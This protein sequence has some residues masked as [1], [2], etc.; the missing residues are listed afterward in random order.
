M[1]RLDEQPTPPAELLAFWRAAG[2]DAQVYAERAASR[3]MNYCDS[4]TALPLGYVR[5]KEGDEVSA[6]GRRWR[7]HMGGGHA[8]E[9]VTL[10]SVDDDLA[11]VGDQILADIT[12]N[13]GVYATEPEA[14][15]VGDWFD[16]CARLA[17]VAEDRHLILPGHKQPFVGAPGRLADMVAQ[18]EAALERLRG[19]LSVPKRATEC[20]EAMYQRRITGG[21]YGLALVETVAHLNHL[22]ARDE[23][24]REIDAGG[25]WLWRRA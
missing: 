9:H 2:M 22:R 6:G 11:I 18:T 19:A 13:L 20:F 5:I 24:S 17:Q 1:L 8:A 12:P 21:A 16:A 14:D 4:V 15:P 23:A 7:V 3:P 10:W 25:A